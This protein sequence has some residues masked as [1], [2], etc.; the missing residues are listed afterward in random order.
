[1]SR[2]ACK[3]GKDC[4]SAGGKFHGLKRRGGWRFYSS[5]AQE[6]VSFDSTAILA[7]GFMMTPKKLKAV[8]K[9]L[10]RF[11]TDLTVI[12]GRSERRHWAE[13]YIRG[14]LLDSP[15]RKPPWGRGYGPL[16]GGCG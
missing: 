3:Q 6:K 2:K 11:L 9:R 7:V 16:H 10:E 14:L 5:V 15:G 8:R 4:V 13:V 12:M 1:M